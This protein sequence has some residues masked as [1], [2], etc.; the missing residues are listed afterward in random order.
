MSAARSLSAAVSVVRVLD[1][2]YVSGMSAEAWPAYAIPAD[3]IERES[4]EKFEAE[5]AALPGGDAVESVFVVGDPVKELASRSEAAD[6][7]VMG[8][9]GYGPL[10]SVLLGSVSG[11]LVGEAAC[12]VIVIP[13]GVHSHFEQL[14]ATPERDSTP[15]RDF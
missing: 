13:R 10:R 12:P 9:R 2:S 11:R 6:L 8:S 7:V 5:M 3:Q 1:S 4:R 15:Q 14:F